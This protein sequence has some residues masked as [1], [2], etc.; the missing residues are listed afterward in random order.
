MSNSG[1]GNFG[2]KGT[3]GLTSRDFTDQRNDAMREGVKALL[4]M[5][6]G[7]SVA[8]LAFLQAVWATDRLLAVAVVFGL[9]F[10]LAGVVLAG[11]VHLFRVHTSN[12]TQWYL[13]L[14]NAGR[15]PDELKGI[16]LSITVYTNL[17]F[18]S[19][20]L[21]VGLFI[22][23]VLVVLLKANCLLTYGCSP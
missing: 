9:W 14:R 13:E 2:G 3:G 20:Y 11:L 18:G 7:A 4:L 16:Q 10:F 8:L 1:G 6:G 12:D 15:S 17:Y 19:A 23:G 5:N 21:S 22:V